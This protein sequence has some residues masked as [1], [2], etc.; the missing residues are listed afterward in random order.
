MFA[1]LYSVLCSGFIQGSVIY[2]GFITFYGQII[3]HCV[4]DVTD[5]FVHLSANVC[6]DHF[7]FGAV[8]NNAAVNIHVEVCMWACV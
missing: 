3:F 1:F 8:T 6:L 5:L 4:I 2:L 7:Y